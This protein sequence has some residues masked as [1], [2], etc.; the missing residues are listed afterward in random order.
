MHGELAQG[1]MVLGFGVGYDKG[2]GFFYKP[3]AERVREAIR[4]FLAGNQSYSQ[5]A[6]L[7]GVT[8]RGL[9]IIL[10]N[11]IWTGWRVME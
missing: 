2:Q 5:L 9:H 10:R 3:E 8:P 7:V 11:P 6:H 1:T 4:Q